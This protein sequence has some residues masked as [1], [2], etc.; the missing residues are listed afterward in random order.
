MA[1]GSLGSSIIAGGASSVMDMASN[2]IGS[3]ING[4]IQRKT[5]REQNA[6][7]AQE[8]QKNRDYQTEMWHK[9][10]AY[11]TPLA[12][13]QRLKEAGLNP[14]MMLNGGSTGNAQ[15]TPQGS[16]AQGAGL[17]NAPFSFGDKPFAALGDSLSQYL[18][19]K[20]QSDLAL[21]MQAKALA[22]ER[23]K[24]QN[25]FNFEQPYQDE[26][27]NNL[28]KENDWFDRKMRQQLDLW[29]AQ[30]AYYDNDRHVSHLMATL[31]LPQEVASIIADIDLKK[32][33]NAL[34]LL[35]I[36]EKEILL[37]FL[38]EQLVVQIA[39]MVSQGRYYDAQS[40]LADVTKD[41]K[42]IEKRQLL[43]TYDTMVDRIKSENRYYSDYF[44]DDNS[45]LGALK[46]AF[47]VRSK[48]DM[49]FEADIDLK[50]SGTEKNK[51]DTYNSEHPVVQTSS[52][53]MKK[54]DA[55]N[56]ERLG[57]KDSQGGYRF[58]KKGHPL[59]D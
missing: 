5:M 11:N 53:F 4:R 15:S 58:V 35:S 22:W 30:R 39:L 1:L 12:Q 25:E 8:A 23:D 21:D 6:F 40:A 45:I 50:H 27:V 51:A 2:A 3:L 54:W 29:D 38:P 9:Q 17:P 59:V 33:Q 42:G 19:D 20:R 26:K 37:K 41:I 10:N 16:Q 57:D 36:K 46:K 7:N 43:D 13:R 55:P 48:G 34:N 49:S 56:Y 32:T 14:Y 47:G 52:D 28:R 31:R 44:G 24:Q 18:H